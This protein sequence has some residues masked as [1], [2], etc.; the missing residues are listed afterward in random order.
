MELARAELAYRTC[1]CWGAGVDCRRDDEVLADRVRDDLNA[2]LSFRRL[3]FAP[4]PRA[5]ADDCDV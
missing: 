4:P 3:K 5:E 2:G 1:R